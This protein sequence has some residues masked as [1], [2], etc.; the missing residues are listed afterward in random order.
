M[1]APVQDKDVIASFNANSEPMGEEGE[2][3]G[4]INRK[5]GRSVCQT[6]GIG[7]SRRR[8][9]VANAEIIEAYFARRE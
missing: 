2:S 8:V 5:S 6:N 7:E 3:R 1:R 9:R 4:R